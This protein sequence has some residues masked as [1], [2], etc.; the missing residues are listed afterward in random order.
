MGLR[1]DA[2]LLRALIDQA[3]A[4]GSLLLPRLEP[5]PAALVV[6]LGGTGLGLAAARNPDWAW[7]SEL[8]WLAL[9]LVLVGML[10]FLLMRREGVG[11]QL[12]L[13]QKRAEPLGE[14]GEPRDLQGEGWRLFCVAGSKRRSLALELRHD[15]GGRPLR[16]FQTRGGAD[17]EEHRL[18]SE[19]ADVLAARLGLGREGLSL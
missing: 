10:M 2:T 12:D 6:T 7:R 14:V 9:G 5:H 15:D 3:R 13:Q 4:A 19:L 18:T 16:L 17:R 11:W 1:S 8:G